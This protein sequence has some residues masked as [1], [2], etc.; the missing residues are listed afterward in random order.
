MAFDIRPG[1]SY[2]IRRKV[3]KLFGAAFHIYDPQGQVV[4]YCKQK[5]FK[6]KEDI[7]IFTDESCTTELVAIKARSIIDFGA[8]YD[9]YM[10]GQSEGNTGASLG[11]FRR[12]GLKSS[13]LR[14]HWLIFDRNGNQV[15]EMLE[16]G[17]FLAFARRYIDFVSIL[18]PQKFTVKKTDGT[19]IARY[20][21]HFNLF[22]YR[23][24]VA[25]ERDD[26][27]LDDLVILAGGCLICA[28][29]GRQAG[30]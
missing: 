9:V 4:G 25:V 16:D 20:R 22:V 30:G 21:Q 7:R 1:E 28:I 8:S 2:T 12:K 29:E 5:A 13:F 17:S 18:S 6:L 24:S 23:L 3:F 27:Q 14:D 19:V 26:P 15:A 10:G 11:S